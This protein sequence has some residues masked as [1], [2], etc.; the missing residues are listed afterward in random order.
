MTTPPPHLNSDERNALYK[1][2][3]VRLSGIG[4]VLIAIEKEDWAA[5]DRLAMEFS[6]LLQLV[7]DLGWGDEGTG[8]VLSTPRPVLQ[9]ALTVLNKQAE[10]TEE[11]EMRA[12]LAAQAEH[13]QLVRQVCVRR[14][15]DLDGPE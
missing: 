5:A 2:I 7:V 1:S 13:N 8:A 11:S 15:A 3:V 9:R 10:D 12:E 4:D 6:A 14:L